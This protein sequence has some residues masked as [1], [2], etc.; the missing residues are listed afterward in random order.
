MIGA[1]KK[2]FFAA[3]ALAAL[4]GGAS[5]A[6]LLPNGKQQFVQADGSPCVGCKIFFF[7]PQTTT[8]K[9]T[10]T[11]ADQTILNTN[12]VITDSL[13]TAVIF[14]SGTYRQILKDADNNTLWDQPTADPVALNSSWAG[15]S[16]GSP[17]AQSVVLD[18][19]SGADGSVIQFLAGFSNS[20]PTTLSVNG[21]TPIPVVLDTGTG[22]QALGGGEIIVANVVGVL[23]VAQSGTF[24]I[25]T[26]VPIQAFNSAIYFNG[27]ISP[28]ILAADQNDWTP[29]G[30]F[31]SANTVRV[32]S[33]V[34]ISITGMTGGASG[35]QLYIQNVG[36]YAIT[37]PINSTAS[38]AANRFLLSA[39]IVLRPNDTILFQYDS[40]SSGWRSG[41][42]Q[43][44]LPIAGG[45]KNLVLTNGGTP[46]NQTIGTADAFTLENTLGLVVRR[47]TLSCTADVTASG[48]GGL[49]TGSVT[50]NTWYSY[51]FIYN[52]STN[53]DSCIFSTSSS[54]PTLPSGYTFYARA[55]WNRTDGSS[56][57]NRVTQR[58]RSA[59]YVVSASVTTNLPFIVP[60]G[61]TGNV[62]TP[63]WT[64]FAV[65]AYVPPTA[66]RIRLSGNTTNANLI[67]AP[68]N[69][70]GGQASVTNPPPMVVQSSNN[71]AGYGDFLL[72]GANIYAATNASGA[73]VSVLGWEDNL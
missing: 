33:N 24:H 53:T 32:S 72:E 58:G 28:T 14:G 6:S 48:A 66:S 16:S 38:T 56:R 44:A 67:C 8:P 52:P 11:N 29:T 60:Q 54:I 34:A 41:A 21:E 68:N 46:N 70:F 10:W 47:L 43:I 19:W 73:T 37:F 18:G 27:I 63:V 3:I 35:R 23:Y 20:G 25:I 65:A 49:D 69:L 15:E 7:I 30:G 61:V 45:F 17:N 64:A 42:Q 4:S 22:P 40:L 62:S 57:F 39:P 1:I 50:T 31:A 55:G 59:Q 5:A 2:I 13:G 71:M 12:P 26:P 9:D 51:W 36:S